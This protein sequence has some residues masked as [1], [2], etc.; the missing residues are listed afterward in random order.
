MTDLVVL[1]SDGGYIVK[2]VE[3]G[4][5]IAVCNFHYDDFIIVIDSVTGRDIP[6]ADG[7]M[8]MAFAHGLNRNCVYA[9]VSKTLDDK[10][11]TELKVDKGESFFLPKWLSENTK[12]RHMEQN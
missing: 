4:I 5:D 11:S 8:R 9:V 12:C 10:L 2:A 3:D 7:V 1:E 6:L